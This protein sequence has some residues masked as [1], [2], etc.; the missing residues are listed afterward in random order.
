MT[1]YVFKN[2]TSIGNLDA[3][4]DSFLE[5]CFIEKE[6]YNILKSFDDQENKTKRI[7]VGRT[8]S[9]KTAILRILKNQVPLYDQTE[10]A[11]E[12]TVFDYIKNNKFIMELLNN[13]VDL[14]IFFKALWNHVILVKILKLLKE[15]QSFFMA[16]KSKNKEMSKYVDKYGDIFFMDDV[17]NKITE[18]FQNDLEGSVSNKLFSLKGLHNEEVIQEMQGKTNA[19]VNKELLSQQR[20][21][22]EYL[23]TSFKWDKQKKIFITIDD[24]DK[25]WL[26]D[27]SIKYSFI[28]SLLESIKDFLNLSKLK[29][30]ISIRTD[31]LEGVY[32]NSFRQKEKDLS[33][34]LPIE[35]TRQEIKKLLDRRINYLLK[36][37]Y[38][39]TRIATLD[40][41]FNFQVKKQ[42]AID[43]IIDRTMMRPR[44]AIDFVNKCFQA[45]EGK[46]SISEDNV[47]TA[48]NF[49]FTSRKEA[50]RDEWKALYPGVEQYINVILK[51]VSK[52]TFKL[53]HINVN[54]AKDEIMSCDDVNDAIVLKA[55]DNKEDFVEELLQVLFEIGV[56]GLKISKDNIIYSNFKKRHL[57]VSD[58]NKEFFVHPLF[59][60]R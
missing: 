52:Q 51:F 47:I 17:L 54:K 49:F 6:E 30:I 14:K 2:N 23:H 22:I 50:L 18:T 40:D 19:Y 35:W 59:W 21:I 25:S 24:L 45:A 57:D 11:A 34:I 10:L 58:F 13:S 32:K 15:N 46:T 28:D 56:I 8:G 48:E 42:N 33:L 26:T 44:D 7:L 55:L 53:S 9:G 12:T 60:R 39:T 41:I 27:L 20:K 5:N 31:I 38:R 29:I 1:E 43:Y 3:E 16:L 37:K 4:T 36:D